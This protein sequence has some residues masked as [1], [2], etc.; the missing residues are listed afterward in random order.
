M[1]QQQAVEYAFSEEDTD[2]PTTFVPEES[3]AGAQR[4]A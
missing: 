3:L 1:G 4:A 2:Q